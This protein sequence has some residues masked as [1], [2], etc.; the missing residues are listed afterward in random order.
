MSSSLEDVQ[1]WPQLVKERTQCNAASEGRHFHASCLAREASHGNN[2]KLVKFDKKKKHATYQLRHTLC[3]DRLLVYSA[4]SGL[5]A[6]QL[7]AFA[8]IY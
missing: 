8:D 5:P 3:A 2:T 7:G 4:N 1:N 6:G